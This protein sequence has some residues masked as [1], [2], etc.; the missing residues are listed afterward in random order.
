[1]VNYIKK[2]LISS[3]ITLFLITFISFIFVALLPGE[4]A[5]LLLGE[6]ATPEKVAKI[7][8]QWGLDKPIILRY[9]MWLKNILQGDFGKSI[10][11]QKPTLGL[12]KNAWPVSFQLCLMAMIF[13]CLTGIPAGI[14]IVIL[15]PK[16]Q[17]FLMSITL[18]AQSIP[19][20]VTGL[21]LIIIISINLKLLPSSGYVSFFENP[22]KNLQAMLLPSISLGLVVSAFLARFTRGCILDILQENYIRTARSKGL[23]EYVILLKHSFRPALIPIVSLLGTQI[24]WFLGGAIIQE[25]VFVLPGMG[26]LI[27]RSVMNRDYSV[28]Q[29]I[30]LIMAATAALANLAVDLLYGFLDP[31]IRYD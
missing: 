18:I 14:F 30:I 19:S 29:G 8:S 21:L 24:V 13:S 25:I 10:L 4:P 17:R 6:F 31:R 1:M 11:S 3:I 26:R 7:N 2:R 20:F 27:V 28:I 16:S 23:K 22:L 12:I 15:K 5:E 9:F